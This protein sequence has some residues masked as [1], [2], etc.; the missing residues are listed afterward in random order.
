MDEAGDEEEEG[1]DEID[2]NIHVTRVLL[3]EDGQWGD[4][5]SQDDQKELLI[6]CHYFA[7]EFFQEELKK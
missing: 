7:V 4:E 6:I 3:Q 2:N 1:Q 5:N